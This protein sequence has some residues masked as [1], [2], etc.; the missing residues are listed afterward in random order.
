VRENEANGWGLRRE[1]QLLYSS[2]AKRDIL[3]GNAVKLFK[4]DIDP[5]ELAKVT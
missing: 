5:R 4:L 2:Q 1:S 3:G